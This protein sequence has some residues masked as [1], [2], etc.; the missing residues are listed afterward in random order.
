MSLKEYVETQANK[1]RPI[2]GDNMAQDAI[3]G[4]LSLIKELAVNIT[5]N[6]KLIGE[7]AAKALDDELTPYAGLR[8]PACG[9]FDI[10]QHDTLNHGAVCTVQ[11]WCVDCEATWTATYLFDQIENLEVPE[12]TDETEA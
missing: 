10:G 2:M 9:S 5:E 8:C 6:K 3:S 4:I 1:I 11:G 7:L 12:F